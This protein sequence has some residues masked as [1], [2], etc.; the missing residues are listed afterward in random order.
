MSLIQLYS[1]CTDSLIILFNANSDLTARKDF[2]SQDRGDA[3]EANGFALAMEGLQHSLHLGIN[4]AVLPL[5]GPRTQILGC[6]KS[7]CKE[8]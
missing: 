1:A 5:H 7:T 3:A 8:R 4:R 6:T 2:C